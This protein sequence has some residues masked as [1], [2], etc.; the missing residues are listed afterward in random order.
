MGLDRQRWGRSEKRR[1]KERLKDWRERESTEGLYIYIYIYFANLL[2]TFILYNFRN[3][4]KDYRI[5]VMYLIIYALK[6]K[7]FVGF[8]FGIVSVT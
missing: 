6:F 4:N 8:G 1:E 2:A 5:K 3:S 7:E